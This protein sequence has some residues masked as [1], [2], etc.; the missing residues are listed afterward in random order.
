MQNSRSSRWDFSS[1]SILSGLAAIALAFPGTSLLCSAA[2]ESVELD[3]DR[4]SMKLSSEEGQYEKGDHFSTWRWSLKADRWGMYA[5]RLHYSSVSPKMGIQFRLG[6]DSILKTY[7]PRTGENG[8]ER[9]FLLGK[10][11]VPE[12]GEYPITLLAGGDANDASFNVTGIELVPAP[13]G[14]KIAQG[15]DGNI[16]LPAGG[17]ATYS[18][19]M[20]YEPREEKNCLGFWKNPEDWAEW[21]FDVVHPGKYQVEVVQGCGKDQGGSEVAVVVEDVKEQEILTFEVEDTG[22]FQNWKSRQIGTV[23]FSREGRHTLSIKPLSKAAKSV[24]DVHKVVLTPVMEE[25]ASN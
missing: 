4:G 15:I 18:E 1:F 9:D 16:E 13:E 25:A 20:R 24:M 3:R 10:V 8:R 7:V 19:M 5:V 12:S 6:Y 2:P 11:Y 23:S 14:D 22:G 17:A 21:E